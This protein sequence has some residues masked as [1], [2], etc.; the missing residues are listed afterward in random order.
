MDENITQPTPIIKGGDYAQ[1]EGAGTKLP[2]QEAALEPKPRP[3]H[4][5]EPTTATY[6]GTSQRANGQ[7][8]S[9][10]WRRTYNI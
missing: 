5:L 4:N 1:E 10:N 8:R 9:E 6:Y 7:T 2:K 3:N